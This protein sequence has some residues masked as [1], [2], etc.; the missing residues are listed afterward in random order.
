[1]HDCAINPNT[2]F[3]I[4][5]KAMKGTLRDIYLF[6]GDPRE[7]I[8]AEYLFTVNVAKTLT[9]RSQQSGE[10]FKIRLEKKTGPLIKD[11]FPI[12]RIERASMFEKSKIISTAISYNALEFRHGRV[13][14][15][16]YKNNDAQ[17]SLGDREDSPLCVIE[18]KAFNPSKVNILK[19][20][21]RN[22]ALLNL[23]ANTGNNA[24]TFTVFS[25]FEWFDELEIDND[26]EHIQK[27]LRKYQKIIDSLRLDDELIEAKLDIF[28]VKKSHGDVYSNFEYNN[29]V[30]EDLSEIDPS[31][32]HHYIGVI[33]TFRK[34]N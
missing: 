19:D 24:L 17:S 33:I 23:K 3:D 9:E 6:D 14:I 28:P 31:T 1:M 12:S 22:I 25:S 20:L 13:D 29:G 15:A 34:I 11:C 7:K 2:I 4:I 16:V 32:K 27:A 30:V 21:E 8:Q 10:P 5:K 18:L 26:E